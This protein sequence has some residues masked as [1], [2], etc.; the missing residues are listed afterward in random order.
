MSRLLWVAVGAILTLTALFLIPGPT[1][2]L[3]DQGLDGVA[4]WR[5]IFTQE[6]RFQFNS[7]APGLESFEPTPPPTKIDSQKLPPM[8]QPGAR[9]LV[10]HNGSGAVPGP[11]ERDGMLD[12][13]PSLAGLKAYLLVLI[14]EDRQDHGLDPVVLDDNPAGQEHAE[15][16]RDYCYLGPR[17][18]GWLEAL[19]AI[20]FD[21]RPER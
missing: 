13:Q 5:D 6:D 14:N 19:H 11:I 8:P 12:S 18:Q 21:R 7:P 16:M 1:S 2:N 9:P 10:P 20:R 4:W 17:G 3:V 15:D